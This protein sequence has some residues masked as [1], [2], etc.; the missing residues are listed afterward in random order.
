MRAPL[1]LTA[2]LAAAGCQ[3]PQAGGRPEG[4]AWTRDLPEC[5]GAEDCL[6]LGNT[7]ATGDTLPTNREA[8]SAAYERACQL[9]SAKGCATLGA[10]LA[11]A[12]AAP[13]ETA[14]GA[15]FLARGC[16]LGAA[17]AC[18]YLG[19]V[20]Y[21]GSKDSSR[22]L[23]KVGRLFEKGCELDDGEGCSKAGLLFLGGRGMARDEKRALANLQRGAGLGDGASSYRLGWNLERGALGTKDIAG[24]NRLYEKACGAGFGLGCSD[25][26]FNYQRGAGV[27][28]DQARANALFERACELAEGFGCN[29]LAVALELGSG[30]TKDQS[31]ANALYER[32]CELRAG[33]GCLNLGSNYERA[34][35]VSWDPATA[36]SLYEKACGL[37]EGRGCRYLASILQKGTGVPR[38]EKR[39]MELLQR[40]CDLG[41]GGGCSDLGLALWKRAG[42]EGGRGADRLFRRA[43]DLGEGAGCNNLAMSSEKDPQEVRRLLA[44][45]CSLGLPEGCDH[46]VSHLGEGSAFVEEAVRSLSTL[47]QQT[48]DM[49]AEVE[50]RTVVQVVKASSRLSPGS[51]VRSA[52]LDALLRQWRPT[53]DASW[54]WREV[55][56]DLLGRG[57]V[58]EA[59]IAAR[60]VEDPYLL[61]AMRVDK[62]FRGLVEA[63]PDLFRIDDALERE[64]SKFR[65]AV[66]DAPRSLR[67]LVLLLSSLLKV[68][69]YDEV[70]RLAEEA[71]RR[72]RSAE[73]SYDDASQE[74]PWVMNELARA[75]KGLGR[76]QEAAEQYLD[77]VRLAGAGAPNVNQA[78]NLA[79]LYCKID[80]PA[81][82]LDAIKDVRDVSPYGRMQLESV[83]LMA[84]V[85]LGESQKAANALAFLRDHR[86]DAEGTFQSALLV[87]SEQDEAAGVLIDRLMDPARRLDALLGVQEFAERPATPRMA[88]WRDLTK[89]LVARPDVQRAI[90]KVGSVERF[91]LAPDD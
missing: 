36:S 57:L 78:I 23:E 24:A 25:L 67:K 9:G 47:A 44:R 50:R 55:C 39:A 7:Y 66:R 14:R 48:P 3:H 53:E 35:G 80:R 54:V 85:E 29:N 28:H 74:L 72:A 63:R 65:A 30:V 88:L 16:E 43:C 8:A 42:G 38:D 83:R 32:A 91:D 45:A 6:R 13:E 61:A 19:T 71:I 69:R 86:A 37:R 49:L 84:A 33:L 10:R 73:A 81:E 56:L 15:T 82:A 31:R 40:A 60:R 1:F 22:D 51:E 76:W 46:L 27:R 59:A 90:S 5:G 87:S 89:A 75:L 11:K 18:T 21:A 26:G 68:P 34:A 20:L 70:I 62:R 17:E 4:I 64:A 2:L 12:E 41:D 77:A 79:D 52:L 58:S